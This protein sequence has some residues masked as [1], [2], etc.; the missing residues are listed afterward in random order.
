MEIING[1]IGEEENLETRLSIRR[2]F[3]QMGI[4]QLIEV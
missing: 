2:E 4:I 3:V 1:L